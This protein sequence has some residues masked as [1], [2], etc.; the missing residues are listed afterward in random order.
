MVLHVN[1][2]QPRTPN[3]YLKYHFVGH[4]KSSSVSPL[5]LALRNVE[6]VSDIRI[7]EQSE[8]PDLRDSA[9]R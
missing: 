7:G 2:W 8:S 1:H 5:S 9:L 6:H 3:F 4:S